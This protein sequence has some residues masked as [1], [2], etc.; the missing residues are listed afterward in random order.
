[1]TADE[2]HISKLAGDM[3]YDKE[4]HGSAAKMH[5]EFTRKNNIN[6]K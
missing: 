1:M 5:N 3:K 6:H 4:H 2:K